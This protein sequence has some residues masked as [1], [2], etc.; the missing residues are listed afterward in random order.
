V[1]IAARRARRRAPT[2]RAVRAA[3]QRLPRNRR[4]TDPSMAA[5]AAA[6]IRLAKVPEG[7]MKIPI[8]L[9]LTA[10]SAMASAE[11]ITV[12]AGGDLQAALDRAKPG[13]VV[14]LE[15]GATF[16]GHFTLP[17]KS[18]TTMTTLRTGGTAAVA[19]GARVTPAHAAN[20]AKLQTPD[21][22]PALQT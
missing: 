7:L 17:V 18:G 11:T 1:A 15:A 20:L 4:K 21:T 13:D 8:A 3:R 14:E 6:R 12:P 5:T 9:L 10:L 22:E 2:Q 19:E 16:S